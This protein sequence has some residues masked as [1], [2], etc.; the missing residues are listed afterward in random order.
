MSPKG[1]KLLNLY[2]QMAE[3]GYKR[4]DGTFVPP[5]YVYSSF[6]LRKYAPHVKDLLKSS[7]TILDYGCG[8]SDWTK[9]EFIP[10]LKPTA[11]EYFNLKKAYMYEPA[12]NIDERQEVDTV[13]CFDVLEHLFIADLMPTLEDIFYYAK[14]S[15][16]LNIAGYKAQALLPNGENAHTIVM[17]ITWW[18]GVLDM[19]SIKFPKVEIHILYSTDSMTAQTVAPWKANDWISSE[20]FGLNLINN[21]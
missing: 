5:E 12:R 20:T 17:P 16:I 1:K 13:I 9:P 11:I 8:G 6:E 3:K 7:E 2:T 19:V 18:K 15:V 21:S 14:K 10:G 4:S